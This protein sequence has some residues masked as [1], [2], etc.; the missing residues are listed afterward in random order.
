MITT[1]TIKMASQIF[2]NLPVSDLEASVQFF[3]YLGFEFNARFGDEN[4]A[5]MIIAD[6][7]FVMLLTEQRFSEFTDKPIADAHM[8]TEVLLSMD[9]DSKEEVDEMVR[10]AVQAGGT[11]YAEAQDN[12]FMYHHSFADL[13]GHQWEVG[14]MDFSALEK[15]Q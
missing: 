12:G 11:L 9:A 2:I 7:I 1:K 4:T 13:D 10:R 8:Q 15:D 5:C 6:N 14:Y 3:S